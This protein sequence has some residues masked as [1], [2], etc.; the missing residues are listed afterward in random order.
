MRLLNDLEI[1]QTSS[2]FINFIIGSLIGLGTYVFNKYR[3]DEPIT[4]PG[5]TTAAGFGA[6]TGGLGGAA[7]GAAGGGLIGNLVWR[8]GFAVINAAGQAIAQEQT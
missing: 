3:H 8:P 5:A 1:E 2:G 7:V 4:I 6:V